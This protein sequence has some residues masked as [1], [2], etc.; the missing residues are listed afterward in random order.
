MTSDGVTSARGTMSE[1]S[2]STIEFQTRAFLQNQFKFCN[3]SMAYPTTI[4]KA[5]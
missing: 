5:N 1:K 3:F 2:R 4:I